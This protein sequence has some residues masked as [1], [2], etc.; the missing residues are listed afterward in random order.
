MSPEEAG[1]AALERYPYEPAEAT[2]RGLIFH[3]EAWH[4]AML[5]I[6]GDRYEADH[7]EL[8]HP[9]PDYLALE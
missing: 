3:D 6:H 7:P 4:R 1:E 8:V 9:S 2:N 5:A